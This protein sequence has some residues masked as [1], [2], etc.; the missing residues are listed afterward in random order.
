M[1]IV[2]NLDRSELLE[3]I[4]VIR[5]EEI[6]TSGAVLP[7]STMYQILLPQHR[8]WP[9]AKNQR[10]WWYHKTWASWVWLLQTHK[11]HLLNRQSGITLLGYYVNTD[12]IRQLQRVI[13]HISRNLFLENMLRCS[14]VLEIVFMKRGHHYYY[15]T[16]KI[17]LLNG[18]YSSVSMKWCFNHPI[19]ML[20]PFWSPVREFCIPHHI[21]Q[22]IKNHSN[23]A[24]LWFTAWAEEGKNW[25]MVCVV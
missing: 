13:L 5:Y 7:F 25:F 20:L 4:P 3:L 14:W 18:S 21:R 22:A 23:S 17:M 11:V 2:L 9:K 10:T 6:L 8:K 19:A 24:Q 16:R 12:N 1:E 15:L